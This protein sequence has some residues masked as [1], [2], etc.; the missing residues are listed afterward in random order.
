M[1]DNSYDQFDEVIKGLGN[2]IKLNLDIEDTEGSLF[3]EPTDLSKI[4]N[5]ST[6]VDDDDDD[7]L[8]DDS[9]D[10]V[11]NDDDTSN[12]DDNTDDKND[13]DSNIVKNIDNKDDISDLGEYES[14]I[15][16]YVTE[17]LSSKLGE[18][19]GEFDKVEDIIDKL[20]EI[21]E[22]NSTPDYANEE[23]AKIDKFVRDGGNLKDYYSEVYEQTLSVDTLD[24]EDESDQKRVIKQN[25][26]NNG[27]SDTQ[28]KK[29]IERYEDAGVLQEEAE[30]AVELVK[31][32]NKKKQE[33]LLKDQE[34]VSAIREK[35]QQK[36]VSDVQS[37]IK[38]LKDIAGIPISNDQK[39][40]LLKYTLIF[41][42]DGKTAYQNEYDKDLVKNFIISA[43]F[44]KYK[45]SLLEKAE[46]KG[47]SDLAKQLQQKF[48][49]KGKRIKKS[50]NQN[51][52]TSDL[53]VFDSFAS[54]LRRNRVN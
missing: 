9:N 52:S 7:L 5:T 15:A 34:N 18:D 48:A 45:D 20:A 33:K 43:F 4:K 54:K 30:E 46:K 39:R 1:N 22:T 17:K 11:D 50:T 31:E 41:N 8:D 10:S 44:V 25:L 6:N 13:K 27:Y 28:I 16:K 40:E 37:T 38:G 35:Q 12:D 47:A 53:E 23:V 51:D 24:L 36:F 2:P 21:V 14:D 49:Q 3:D 19:I 29:K 42:K 26:K 32:F